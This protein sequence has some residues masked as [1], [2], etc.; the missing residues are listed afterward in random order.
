MHDDASAGPETL[1]GEAARVDWAYVGKLASRATRSLWV[2]VMVLARDVGRD[3]HRPD[4]P[5]AVR[6]VRAR[7]SRWA[8]RRPASPTVARDE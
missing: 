4:G 7:C 1:R 2:F 3:H 8:V 6:V 5:L